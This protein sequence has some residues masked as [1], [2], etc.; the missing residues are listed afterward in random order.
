M[1]TREEIEAITSRAIFDNAYR[2]RLLATPKKAAEELNIK[3]TRKE[4]QYIKGLDP[5]EVQRIA[6]DVQSITQTLPVATHWK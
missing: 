2:S 5:K 4:I 1:A 6:V 3:L